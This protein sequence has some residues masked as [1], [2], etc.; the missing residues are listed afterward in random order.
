MLQKLNLL[1]NL[2]AKTTKDVQFWRFT[3]N[4][5]PYIYEY[6]NHHPCTPNLGLRFTWACASEMDLVQVQ[7]WAKGTL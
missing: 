3:P 5:D 1:C 2:A 6:F 4:F 7:S